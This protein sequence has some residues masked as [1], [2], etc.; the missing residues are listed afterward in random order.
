MNNLSNEELVGLIKGGK[1]EYM[2]EL[3][4]RNKKG[5]KLSVFNFLKNHKS[6]L[7][8]FNSYDYDDIYQIASYY[9][10][11]S[12]DDYDENREAKYITFLINYLRWKLSN[13]FFRHGKI[14][15]QLRPSFN[16]LTIKEDTQGNDGTYDYDLEKPEDG[17]HVPEYREDFESRMIIDD[18]LSTLKERD[19]NM[20][21]DYYL[22]GYSMKEVAEKYDMVSVPAAR[23]LIY[24][25]MQKLRKNNRIYE[26]NI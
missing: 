3:F 19:A 17:W 4:I 1:K 14:K 12:V 10:I 11:Q 18:L 22:N 8:K 25:T 24:K 13:H 2:D 21:R 15:F 9:F 26:K 23:T 6:T 20:I 5:I 7:D 16:N